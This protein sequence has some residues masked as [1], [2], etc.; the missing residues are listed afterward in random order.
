M[1][2]PRLEPVLFLQENGSVTFDPRSL[3]PPAE[4]L[5]LSS[6]TLPA[7]L[8][9]GAIR[10]EAQLLTPKK[11]WDPI[12]FVIHEAVSFLFWFGIG[13]AV[14]SGFFRAKKSI[15]VYLGLRS[16][17]AAFLIVH[18]V[19]NFAWRLQVLAWLAFGIYVTV[20]GLRWTLSKISS[21][22]AAA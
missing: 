4:F 20:I 6:G 11:L 14:E 13:L 10:P 22:R 21:L 8:L 2:R 5:V 15:L 17:F 9:S 3:P 18:G 1:F 16:C 7:L 12:W 19:A